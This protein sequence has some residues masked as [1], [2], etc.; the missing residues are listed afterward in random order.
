MALDLE[1]Y[2][3]SVLL[4][5]WL[6]HL[7]CKIVSEM[8]YN[9]SSWTLNPTIPIPYHSDSILS[10]LGLLSTSPATCRSSHSVQTVSVSA[11]C[12]RLESTRVHHRP[13]STRRRCHI[14]T[15]C[16]SVGNDKRSVH[17]AHQ[18]T[19]RRTSIPRRRSQGV[20][21]TP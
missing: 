20:E 6:G 18:T 15:N 3:P 9:V 13:P 2:H 5:C 19:V 16:S 1:D 10:P 17:S 4:H 14:T 11:P 12:S 8:T 21:P 7:T